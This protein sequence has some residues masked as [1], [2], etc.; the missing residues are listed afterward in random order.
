MMPSLLWIS[1]LHVLYS[2]NGVLRLASWII[3]SPT[4]T[5]FIMLRHFCF[6][7]SKTQDMSLNIEVFL[8]EHLQTVI[9]FL[10]FCWSNVWF[11]AQWHFS[12][13]WYRYFFHFQWKCLASVCTFAFFFFFCLGVEIVSIFS[14]KTF[15]FWDT[16]H[17]S[18]LY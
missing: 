12:P 9:C 1:V 2:W 16:A 4:V 18:F 14:T 13:C 11:V 17:I 15:Y 7:F 5:I 3:F 8:L 10:C 6:S